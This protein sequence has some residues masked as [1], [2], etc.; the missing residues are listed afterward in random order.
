MNRQVSLKEM[1][2]GKEKRR[3]PTQAENMERYCSYK[4]GTNSS[5]RNFEERIKGLQSMEIGIWWV[6]CKS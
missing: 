4:F 3:E 5:Q 2:E 1:E 6:Y